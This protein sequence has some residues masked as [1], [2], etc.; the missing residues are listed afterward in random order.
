MICVMEIVIVMKNKKHPFKGLPIPSPE[1]LRKLAEKIAVKHEEVKFI[2][3]GIIMDT[4]CCE[5][6]RKYK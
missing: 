3:G 4:C 1:E 6:H 5:C 2:T